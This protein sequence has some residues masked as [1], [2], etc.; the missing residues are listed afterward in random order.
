MGT[1]KYTLYSINKNIYVYTHS[2]YYDTDWYG[3]IVTKTGMYVQYWFIMSTANMIIHYLHSDPI[4]NV[5]IFSF[6]RAT[7]R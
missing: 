5:K 2:V 3:E 6:I 7:F 4:Q 1:S